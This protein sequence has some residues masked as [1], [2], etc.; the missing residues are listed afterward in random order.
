MLR[1]RLSKSVRS[2]RATW[3]LCG[4]S[5]AALQ[6]RARP[7][8]S[9]PRESNASTRCHP[10]NP[11]APVT[12]TLMECV[13]LS[14][15]IPGGHPHQVLGAAP[16]LADR[17]GLESRVHGAIGATGVLPR[18]PVLPVGLFREFLPRMSV[19]RG[20]EVAGPLPS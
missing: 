4:Y 16:N 18:L 19:L 12:K 14:Q 20:G 11:V 15:K 2:P 7:R 5:R 10:T 8:T 17:R 3:V 6:G 1:L 13:L 9:S